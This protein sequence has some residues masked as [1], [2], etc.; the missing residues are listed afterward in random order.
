MLDRYT[1][2]PRGYVPLKSLSGHRRYVNVSAPFYRV[3]LCRDSAGDLAPLEL[4]QQLYNHRKGTVHYLLM[5][6]TDLLTCR[7][8]CSHPNQ[9]SKY[10]SC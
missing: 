3:M 5:I 7:K 8:T 1:T 10:W 9:E 6:V 4:A 2:G